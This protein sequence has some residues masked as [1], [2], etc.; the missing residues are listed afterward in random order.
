METVTFGPYIMGFNSSEDVN[1]FKE[2]T[3]SWN[4]W[5]QGFQDKVK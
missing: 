1:P 3:D 5:N 2:N 4:S